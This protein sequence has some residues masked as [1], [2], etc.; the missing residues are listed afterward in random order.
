MAVPNQIRSRRSPGRPARDRDFAARDGLIDAATSLFAENG[1]AATT[2]A[3]IAQRAGLTPAM[4]HYYFTDRDHLLDAVVAERLAP[5]VAS[6][7]GDVDS[8]TPPAEMLRGVV[9]RMLDGIDRMPWVPSTWMREV[10]N[11][12]GL[13]R[14][15]IVR[16]IPFEKVRIVTEAI[17][18]EQMRHAANED[19]DPVLMVFSTLGLVMMHMATVQFFAGIF[20]R[21][22]PD[23]DAI[24]R[25]ITALLLHGLQPST[26][27]ST[28][29]AEI[30]EAAERRLRRAAVQHRKKK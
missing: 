7:W 10:L 5:L 4:M 16:C 22:P 19:L 30:A 20:H 29:S 24:C 9:N 18:R 14:T 27:N 21:E 3:L 2:F 26:V 28:A 6:V 25:H 17:A 12:G 8:D 1:V 13:L 23:K 15:R 11:E